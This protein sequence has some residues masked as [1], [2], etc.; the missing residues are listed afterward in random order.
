MDAHL[1]HEPVHIEKSTNRNLHN[2][3]SKFFNLDL[4]RGGGQAMLMRGW[5]EVSP[6][7]TMGVPTVADA[8]TGTKCLQAAIEET[9]ALVREIRA[10][11]ILERTDHH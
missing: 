10:L 3:D 9:T 5:S 2:P 4:A 1:Q 6:D 7:G 11:P 8:A